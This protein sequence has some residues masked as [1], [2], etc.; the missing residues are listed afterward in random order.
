MKLVNWLL[1]RLKKLARTS[2]SG[3]PLVANT[4]SAPLGERLTD[5]LSR[6]WYQGFTT[7]SDFA[8]EYAAHVAMAA[9]SGL[10][11][12]ETE[13]DFYGKTWRITQ[14]GLRQLDGTDA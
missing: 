4:K 13:P 11:T 7:S 5:V 8:R 14:E 12:T 6:A 9:S 2:A 3:F 10:I 1:Q